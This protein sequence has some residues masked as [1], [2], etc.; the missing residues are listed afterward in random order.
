MQ[1]LAGMEVNEILVEAGATLSGALAA[2]G[3]VDHYTVYMA[4][5]LLGSSARPL[6]QLPLAT[7]AEQK[8]LQ[9]DSIQPI[10]NDWRIDSRPA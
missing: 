8:R 3:L 9:I 10:G 7:M 1:I 5:T 2:A 6:L 4:P